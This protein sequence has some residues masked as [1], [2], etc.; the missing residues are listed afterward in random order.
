MS[1]S[2]FLPPVSGCNLKCV[3]KE[4][5]SYRLISLTSKLWGMAGYSWEAHTHLP[6]QLAQPALREVM[7]VVKVTRCTRGS[8]STREHEGERGKKEWGS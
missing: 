6:C 1:P 5:R 8:G 7:K 2:F 3:M 4:E